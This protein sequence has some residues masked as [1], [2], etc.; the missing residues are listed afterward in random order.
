ME[1]KNLQSGTLSVAILLQDGLGG[2]S[3]E[4]EVVCM[5]MNE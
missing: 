2:I 4:K 3:K 1:I 5:I